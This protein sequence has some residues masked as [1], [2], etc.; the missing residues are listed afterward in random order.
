MLLRV[1]HSRSD[2]S[3]VVT[4]NVVTRESG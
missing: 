2:L 4:R 1:R 3:N